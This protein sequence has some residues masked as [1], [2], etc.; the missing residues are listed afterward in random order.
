MIYSLILNGN[1]MGPIK[2]FALAQL[3]PQK[4]WSQA[5]SLEAN[6]P[7]SG[8]DRSAPPLRAP[9][10]HAT[11]PPPACQAHARL[12]S[13]PKMSWGSR[14]SRLWGRKAVAQGPGPGVGRLAF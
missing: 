8:A 10:P 13:A 2:D 3:L 9:T 5:T 4:C 12:L 1:P 7:Q 11:L 14:L 6:A